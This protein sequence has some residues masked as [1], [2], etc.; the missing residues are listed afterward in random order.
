MAAAIITVVI[1]VIS[2]NTGK[3]DGAFI[4]L[5]KYQNGTIPQVG[6]TA[7]VCDC[8]DLYN[9]NI[10]QMPYSKMGNKLLT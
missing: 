8:L 5:F 2:I 7:F 9:L 4:R 6:I 10:Y 1:F 3:Q